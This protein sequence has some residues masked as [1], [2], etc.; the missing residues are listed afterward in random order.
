MVLLLWRGLMNR[1]TIGTRNGIRHGRH[2][3][4]LRNSPALSK[5][6][7]IVPWFYDSYS[8]KLVHESPPSPGY[9]VYAAAIHSGTGWH[10]L[11]IPDNA[12]QAQAQVAANA[13]PGGATAQKPNA[14]IGSLAG[15]V[16]ATAASKATGVPI[17]N[18]EEFLSRLTSANLWLRVGEFIL[19]AL[20]ILSGTMK[21]TN[22]GGDLG[23]IVKTGAKFIK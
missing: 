16:P 23:D 15:N 1:R 2:G 19:G 14:S 7:E 11:A 13:L 4:L 22:H 12:T 21:L 5:V 17:A 10:Q 8:G 6:V 20:L 18:V 9:Y 3:S